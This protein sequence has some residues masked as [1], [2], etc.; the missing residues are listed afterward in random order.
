MNKNDIERSKKL[1]QL[2]ISKINQQGSISIAE[3]IEQALYHPTLGYYMQDSMHIGKDFITAPQLG[4]WLANCIGHCWQK[5]H[6]KVDTIIEFGPGSG[7]MCLDFLLYC[8]KYKVLPKNYYLIELSP[9]L[10]KQ[11]QHL[12]KNLNIKTNIEW[13]T[14]PPT[15]K[16]LIIANEFFDAWPVE[17]FIIQKDIEQ[18]RVKCNQENNLIFCN[19]PLSKNNSI[20]N[21]VKNLYITNKPYYSE[22]QLNYAQWFSDQYQKSSVGGMIIL[23]YG[24]HQKAYYAKDRYQGTIQ[25]FTQH[26]AHSDFLSYPGLQD[27]TAQIDFTSLKNEACKA[28][29]QIAGYSS[30]AQFMLQNGLDKI[31][32]TTDLSI[33]DKLAIKQLLMPSEMG[34]AFKVIGFTKNLAVDWF[35]DHN[36]QEIL[37]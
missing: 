20:Y 32:T 24:M 5:I 3:Y 11:Q 6:N 4:P 12:L 16:C 29:W 19:N 22:I 21:A 35:K 13:L 18:R 30:Q 37:T 9:G 28:G 14:T 36:K 8:K 34:E 7:Q 33:E 1:K 2:I 31:L 27:I 26:R 25:C 15:T 10:K 17:Q 23:D